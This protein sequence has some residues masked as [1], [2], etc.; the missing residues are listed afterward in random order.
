MTGT[1]FETYESLYDLL[2]F[3]KI[4][5][6]GFL[7]FYSMLVLYREWCEL[8]LCVSGSQKSFMKFFTIM[9]DFGSIVFDSEFFAFVAAR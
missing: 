8:G 4:S 6:F 9:F 3:P 2:F 5:F 7:C 1:S